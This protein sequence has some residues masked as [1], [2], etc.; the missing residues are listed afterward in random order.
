MSLSDR[1]R[2]ILSDIEARLHEE[3]PKLVRTVRS[4]TV[5]SQ[6]RRQVKLA[7]AGF[8]VGF[9]LLFLTAVH[10]T[11]GIAGFALMFVSTVHGANMLKRIGSDQNTRLG[12]QLRGGFHRYM[13]GR[14]RDDPRT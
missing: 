6:A 5:S 2:R 9:L 7:V 3:D 11:W 12:G 13:D 8:I 4:T 1:E 14:R 10:I